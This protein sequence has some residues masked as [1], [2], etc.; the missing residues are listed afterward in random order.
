MGFL[1]GLKEVSDYN[2]KRRAKKKEREESVNRNPTE[3][4]LKDNKKGKLSYLWTVFSIIAYIAGFVLVAMGFNENVGVGI[5]AMIIVLMLAPMVQ[6]KAINLAK[7]QR[8]INGKG[9]FA[10]I[11][12]IILPLAVLFIGVFFF[13]FGYYH[14]LVK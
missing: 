9:L 6:K 10:L 3:E 1:K 7:Q 14:M 4:Q 13:A 12:A 8:K 5:F 11:L 2:K